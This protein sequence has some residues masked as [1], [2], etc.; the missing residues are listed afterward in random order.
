MPEIKVK[1]MSCSHCAGAVTKALQSLP[2]VS[3]VQVD[4]AGGRVT[5]QSAAPISPADLARVIK[6]AGFEVTEG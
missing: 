6:A 3:E 5:Y 2:G 1:G 4:L